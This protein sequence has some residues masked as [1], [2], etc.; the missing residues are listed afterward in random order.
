LAVEA[1][2]EGEAERLTQKAVEMTLEGNMA[3]LRLC[4]ERLAPVR[5]EHPICL[6]VPELSAATG[7]EAK[8]EVVIVAVATGRLLPSEGEKLVNL[9]LAQRKARESDEL[10]KRVAALEHAIESS[11]V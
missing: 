2:L 10:E 4:I 1:I 11:T 5:H 3:A 8:V 6:N 9:L 7:T